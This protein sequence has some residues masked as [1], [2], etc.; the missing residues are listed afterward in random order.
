MIHIYLILFLTLFDG[1]RVVSR[2]EIPIHEAR[3]NQYT[4]W[5]NCWQ[6]LAAKQIEMSQIQPPVIVVGTCIWSYDF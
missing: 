5:S 4:G 3:W 2:Y 6:I 1:T